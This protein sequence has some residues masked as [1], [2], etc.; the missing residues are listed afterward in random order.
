MPGIHL[1][2][3]TEEQ[4]VRGF[5]RIRN[6]F[7]VSVGFPPEVEEAAR[8]VAG[9]A[10][11]S[12]RRDLR[13]IPF[14][15]IDP[16]GSRD[17]DQA[18]HAARSGDGYRVRYAIADVGHFVSPGSALDLTARRRG[19]TF[20]APDARAPL[21]PKILNNDAASLLPSVDRPAVVWTHD[22]DGY[23]NIVDTHVE[24]AIVRSR[25]M[26]SY[27]EVEA[28]LHGGSPDEVN[29]LLREIGIA[30]QKK[31][32]TRGGVSLRLPD[33]EVVREDGSFALHFRRTLPVEYWNAQIS[34]L[35]GIAAATLM[36][37]HKVGLLRTLPKPHKQAIA[38]LRRCSRALNV[39]YPDYLA[40]PD[41]V[42]SL[43][44]ADPD[45]AALMSQAARAFGGA[46][47][48]GFDGAVP[49]ETIHGAIGADYSHVTAP[50]RRL[51][52]RFGNEIVLAVA[53]GQRPPGWVVAALETIPDVM[54]DA[55]RRE[56]AFE[57]AMIDFA[58]SLT[59]A[60][61]VGEVFEAVVT[62]A[63]GDKLTLQIRQPA[64][65]ARLYGEGISLGDEIQVRLTAAEPE[66]RS[67]T[68]ELV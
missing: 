56:R 33:Q 14:V 8:L 13:N 16:A 7:E 50:L 34:L 29:I 43:N 53:A 25:R 55:S 10:F 68:F 32:A 1:H 64:I 59:L 52:D 9:A 63:D 67:L 58:E 57:R 3:P 2:F 60:G 28:N 45:Q 51:I 22:L 40:Y 66:R 44:T 21:H 19:L 54:V 12:D 27:E 39:P 62:D 23:A 65:V 20:Y 47:Y 5:D 35:T 4:F 17:L 41:W 36:I 38:W 42:R 11:G 18:F 49:D 15:T 31:E 37:D 6:E 24:R 46:G 30:R 48:I 26:F 61:R